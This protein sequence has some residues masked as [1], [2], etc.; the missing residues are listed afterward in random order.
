M[1]LIERVKN[2]IT[3]IRTN[4]FYSSLYKKQIERIKENTSAKTIYLFCAPTHSNLGDQAQLYC[5]L[6]LFK[7]L[8]EDY[9]VITISTNSS[10]NETLNCIE[11][12]LKEEDLLFIHSGYLI[13][14]PHPELPFICSVINKFSKKAITILPNTVNLI[15]TEKQTEI[16]NCFNSHSNLT[17]ICRDEISLKNAGL[18]FSNCK[19]RLMPDV[20]TSL[21]GSNVCINNH[22]RDGILLCVRNDGEKL[23]SLEEIEQLQGRFKNIDTTI[24]DTTINKPRW[25]WEKERDSLLLSTIEEFSKYKVIITDRYHGTIFSQIANTPVIVLSSTDH[26]LSSG[27]NWFPKEEFADSLFFAHDLE[28]AYNLVQKVLSANKK[29]ESGL[30]FKKNYYSNK[31]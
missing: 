4:R 15:S 7:E 19:L 18:L 24:N 16:S 25:I 9:K 30:Y 22:K 6:K 14:D 10:D 11:A 8:Y 29:I 28:E 5:W 21:I 23:Y 1:N 3:Y 12:S 13:F 17:L 31:F 26:K 27:V 2:K 20:V